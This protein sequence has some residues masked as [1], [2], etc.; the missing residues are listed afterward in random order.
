VAEIWGGLPS[1]QL[2]HFLLRVLLPAK[3]S[4]SRSEALC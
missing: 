3:E 1:T 2:D 4:S